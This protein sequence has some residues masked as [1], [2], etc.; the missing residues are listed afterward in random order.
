M[1]SLRKRLKPRLLTVYALA[2]LLIVYARPNPTSLAIGLIPIALGEGLRLWATGHLHK[3][4]ALTVT[5]PYAYLRNPLYLGTLLIASGLAL[6]AA[7]QLAYAV[8]GVFVLGYFVYYMPYKDRIETARLESIYGD[9]FRR[10]SLAVPSL[11]PRLHA[12]V[13]LAADGSSS[14]EFSVRFRDN[15]EIGTAAAVLAVVLLLTGR[16]AL[17]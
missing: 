8:L 6:I 3:N 16:W 9:A 7:S 15:N 2:I 4:D 11:L 10:Y 12:Y 1:R 5:G 13:P 14:P 17:L